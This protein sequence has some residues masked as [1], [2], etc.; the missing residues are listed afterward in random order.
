[1]QQEK[2]R[3]LWNNRISP[4]CYRIGLACGLSYVDAV[5]GQFIM[6]GLCDKRSPLLRRPF[7]IHRLIYND[8][9]LIG[10]ELLYKVVGACTEMLAGHQEG[11]CVDLLGPL[12][13]GFSIPGTARDIF[14][15]AGGF[16]IAPVIFLFSHLQKR[17]ADLSG[18]HLFLGGGTADDL[19]CKDELAHFE[20]LTHFVTE[21]GSEGEKGLV[22][23]VLEGTVDRNKPDIIYA[24]GP[25]GMLKTIARIA[26]KSSVPCQVSTETVMACGFGVCLGCA[27]ERNNSLEKS[28]MHTC[29]DGPVFDSRVIK[30]Q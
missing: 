21:D 29:V 6:L 30:I 13:N 23:D 19:L 26:E 3:I 22:T 20:I 24:C 10:L 5:P 2:V 15:V 4:S 16:G 8:M 12:G 11:D 25:T 17:A 7:S 28:Y 18:I 1:M 14:V 9:G 27:V